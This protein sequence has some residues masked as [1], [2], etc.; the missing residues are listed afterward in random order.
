MKES[1]RGEWS[2]TGIYTTIYTCRGKRK[3]GRERERWNLCAIVGW[4]GN[5]QQSSA[6]CSMKALSV[7]KCTKLSNY[8]EIHTCKILLGSR[9]LS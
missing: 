4:E 3:K 5:S 9:R 1:T 8:D 2:G 6:K 7:K